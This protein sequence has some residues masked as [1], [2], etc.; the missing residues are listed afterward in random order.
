VSTEWGGGGEA[1]GVTFS[2]SD[3]D[4]CTIPVE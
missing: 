4:V 1:T 2:S 3:L